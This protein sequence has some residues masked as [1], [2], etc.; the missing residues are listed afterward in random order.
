MK[1]TWHHQS[2]AVEIWLLNFSF[3]IFRRKPTCSD[4]ARQN[5]RYPNIDF[6]DHLKFH[7]FFLH[8]NA[9]EENTIFHDRPYGINECPLNALS[10]HAAHPW[11]NRHASRRDPG[12]GSLPSIAGGCRLRITR[13]SAC[14]RRCKITNDV[15][16]LLGFIMLHA[17]ISRS[18]SQPLK[19]T[20]NAFI[21]GVETSFRSH[22]G[23]NTARP[24][25]C[26]IQN[27]TLHA[28]SCLVATNK[29]NSTLTVESIGSQ[30][31]SSLLSRITFNRLAFLRC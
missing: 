27:T 20:R 29:E 7:L 15:I 18:S 24:R 3:E 23:T 11:I 6:F 10:R 17:G 5:S 31:T 30:F 12:F 21:S 26:I 1:K 4:R 25:Y 19:P 14:Q 22:T 16:A 8:W 28:A 2:K 9:L 13:L